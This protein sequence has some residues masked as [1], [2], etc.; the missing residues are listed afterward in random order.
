VESLGFTCGHPHRKGNTEWQCGRA[1]FKS[2]CSQEIQIM[3]VRTKFSN[4]P[5]QDDTQI[6]DERF[7]PEDF[8][9]YKKMRVMSVLGSLAGTYLRKSSRCPDI[10]KSKNPLWE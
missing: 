7:H 1:V 6:T 9:K 4:N 3:V 8:P 10:P 5:E 2:D